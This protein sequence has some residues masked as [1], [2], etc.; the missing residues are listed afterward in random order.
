MNRLWK[1]SRSVLFWAGPFALPGLA[2][3]YV[4]RFYDALPDRFPIRW[5]ARGQ[6]ELWTDKNVQE[7]LFGPVAGWCVLTFAILAE[8]LIFTCLRAESGP[9]PAPGV[10]AGRLRRLRLLGWMNWALGA[11]FAVVAIL[12]GIAHED[13]Q[14]PGWY[15]ATAIFACV[16]VAVFRTLKIK[17]R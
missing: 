6:A 4:Y 15:L 7:V 1:H 2:L 11:A 5:S 9:Y 14:L 8:L 12:P 10:A 16:V 3:L 17:P 13:L